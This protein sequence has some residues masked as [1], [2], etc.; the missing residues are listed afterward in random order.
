MLLKNLVPII[1]I[2]IYR[3]L[4]RGFVSRFH[5][6]SPQK[7]DALIVFTGYLRDANLPTSYV[8][9]IAR[10]NKMVN[11]PSNKRLV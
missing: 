3:L 8:L 5:L 11:F 7:R 10:T 6:V 2:K 4:E 9:S 1:Q